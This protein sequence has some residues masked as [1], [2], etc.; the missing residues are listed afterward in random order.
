[1]A[2]LTT[3]V[4]DAT[5]PEGLGEKPIIIPHVCNDLGL[6][7]SGFVL[8]I[9]K[10]FGDVPRLAYQHWLKGIEYGS[11]QINS[12]Q[13]NYIKT[14]GEFGLGAVQFVR[15]PNKGVLI[16][17]MIAQHKVG[18]D[19]NGRPPIRY[20]ALMTAM[21]HIAYFAYKS[22]AE[23]PE[24]HCPKFGSDLAGGNWDA[25]SEMINEI[26]VDN[27]ID[28]T[29]YEFIPKPVWTPLPPN[30]GEFPFKE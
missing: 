19:K 29:V 25:I 1:M 30:S 5:K 16:A 24:I 2:K 18:F 20:G 12:A 11:D 4:G 9:S 17:N 21:D 15:T 7:G 23:L 13:K 14:T 6:W 22:C 8:A 27:G 10:A 3:V 26:W 28:V